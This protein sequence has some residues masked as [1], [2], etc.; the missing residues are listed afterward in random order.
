MRKAGWIITGLV[1]AF[2]LMDS[3]MKL[4]AI[5]QVLDT[6]AELGFPGAPMA[7]GL[8]VLLLACTLLYITPRTALL[9]AVLV[10]GY[11]GGAVATHLRLGNPLF[12]HTL[13]GVYVGIAMWLGLWLRE[14]RLR[15]VLPV[16]G[17]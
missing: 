14:P 9:G 12:S 13:F 1:T 10:T 5:Q 7:R 6:S 17:R 4:L 2:L 3:V 16:M 8:G 15:G 11:L